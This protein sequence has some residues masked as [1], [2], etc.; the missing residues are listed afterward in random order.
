MDEQDR[1]KIL[2]GAWTNMMYRCNNPKN[3]RYHNYGGRGIKVSSEW[4]SFEEFYLWAINNGH[5]ENLSL[6]R[7][8]ND[9]DYSPDNC[10]WA[11]IK[12]QNINRRNV[13][14]IEIDGETK[15]VMEWCKIYDL[16]PGT[17]YSRYNI[18]GW[19]LVKSITTP[20]QI[21]RKNHTGF[22]DKYAK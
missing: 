17:F 6:E 3:R 12:E 18:Y 13:H 14:E 9:G 7:I 5:Q 21:V 1:R 2:Y 11:T 10:K 20:V 16:N 4:E 22:K 19:D 15:T 8:D